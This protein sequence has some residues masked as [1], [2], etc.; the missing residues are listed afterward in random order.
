MCEGE[1]VLEILASGIWKNP[2]SNTCIRHLSRD[3]HFETGVHRLTQSLKKLFTWTL[4]KVKG[5]TKIV[6]TK[7]SCQFSQ[8]SNCDKWLASEP[9]DEKPSPVTAIYTSDNAEPEAIDGRP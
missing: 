6:F 9:E 7:A 3:F 1:G 4:C 5:G 2:L 8:I